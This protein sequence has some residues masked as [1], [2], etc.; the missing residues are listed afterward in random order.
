M[1]YETAILL[2]EPLHEDGILY[3]HLDWHVSHAAK[4]VLDD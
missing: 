3:V 1:I 4:C 2:H